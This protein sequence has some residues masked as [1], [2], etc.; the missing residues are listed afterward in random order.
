MPEPAKPSRRSN[1]T[2]PADYPTTPSGPT[3]SGLD[4]SF[5]LQMMTDLKGSV[6][7]LKES[8]DN[9]KEQSREH[10][11][12]IEDVRMDVHA[13]KAAGRTLLWVAGVVG[14][15]LGLFIAAYFRQLLSNGK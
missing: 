13:A 10:G 4:H 1:P 9:L 5:L 15:L 3:L 11:K 6:A 12:K 8:V 7:A 14:T 2:T